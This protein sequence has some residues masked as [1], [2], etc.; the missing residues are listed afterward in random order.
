MICLNG[1]LA[2]Q[3]SLEVL[4]L[5]EI[6]TK[7]ELVFGVHFKFK[8]VDYVE[9]KEDPDVINTN[10]YRTC[11]G[12]CLLPKGNIEGTLKV[13]DFNTGVVNN[14]RSATAFP[15]HDRYIGLFNAWGKRS[16]KEGE[17]SSLKLLYR[18]K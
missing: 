8:W 4:S 3:R 15:M 1:S 13:F 17:K 11:P 12:I 5:R 7:I 16:H 14:P 6:A 2:T 9:A 18:H 10:M